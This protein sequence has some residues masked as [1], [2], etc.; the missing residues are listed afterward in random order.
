MVEVVSENVHAESRHTHIHLVTNVTFLGVGGVE[1]A[2]SL[3]VSAQVATCCIMFATV[4][5]SVLGFLQL[6]PA[7]LAPS[8]SNGKLAAVV[9]C[10]CDV[11]ERL[12]LCWCLDHS[13]H[14]MVRDG[15]GDGHVVWDSRAGGGDVDEGGVVVVL[16][17]GGRGGWSTIRGRG[18]S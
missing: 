8:I 11:E 16:L 2:M 6:I 18:G 14:L 4:S 10:S 3:P 5:A 13:A 7:F 15:W 17:G 1:T 12:G 9:V